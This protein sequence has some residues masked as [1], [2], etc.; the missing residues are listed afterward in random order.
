MPSATPARIPVNWTPLRSS[1]RDSPWTHA[2]FYRDLPYSF[3]PAPQLAW[4]MLWRGELPLW[5]PYS[6]FGTPLAAMADL[7]LYYPI[8]ALRFALPFPFG[9]NFF[10]IFHFYLA[11]FGTW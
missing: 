9:F 10:I 7:L 2:I 3:Y 8:T 11:A 6:G 4:N 5:N 1:G